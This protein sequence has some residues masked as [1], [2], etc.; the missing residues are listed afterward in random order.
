MSDFLNW[1]KSKS[2]ALAWLGLEASTAA[3]AVAGIMRILHTG[4][5]LGK[6]GPIPSLDQWL[7]F[8]REPK[9][10]LVLLD[11]QPDYDGVSARGMLECLLEILRL[12]AEEVQAGLAELEPEMPK[13]QK[14]GQR[15]WGELYG[16]S[17]QEVEASITGKPVADPGMENLMQRAEMSYFLRVWVPCVLLYREYPH[18]LFERACGGDICALVDLLKLDKGLIGERRIAEQIHKLGCLDNQGLFRKVN[19]ALGQRPRKMNRR[20]AKIALGGFLS[21]VSCGL[22]QKLE[23]VEIG[24]LFDLAARHASRGKVLV[25]QDLPVGESYGKAIQRDRKDWEGLTQADKDRS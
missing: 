15:V 14:E 3:D 1:G 19:R 21:F 13:L 16:R 4:E 6:L 22:S 24:R 18:R 17:L 11:D 10:L 23:A 12:P 7:A 25:D 8:Y 20:E 2:M 5:G 9:H